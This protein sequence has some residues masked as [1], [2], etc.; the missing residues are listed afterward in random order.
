MRQRDNYGRELVKVYS[1]GRNVAALLIKQGHAVAWKLG[2]PR[3][4]WCGDAFSPSGN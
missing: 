1:N 4:D 3:P 2:D